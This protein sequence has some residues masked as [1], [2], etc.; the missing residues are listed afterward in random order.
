MPDAHK[1]TYIRQH[2]PMQI[3]LRI[4]RFEHETDA[5]QKEPA[6][7]R[8][9]RVARTLVKEGGLAAVLTLM[10]AGTALTE[11]RAEAAA[12]IQCLAGR[13]KLRAEGGEIEL[14]EGELAALN[15]GV[16]HSVAAV[17]ESAFLLTIAT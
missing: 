1:P 2:G 3:P 13:I 17:T 7:T 12:T 9:E 15:S 8:G 10:P 5:L 4:V 6:W 14:M 11:H 16:N